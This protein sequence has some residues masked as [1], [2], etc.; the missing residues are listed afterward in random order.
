MRTYFF[1]ISMVMVAACALNGC[2]AEMQS[3]HRGPMGTETNRTEVGLG[4]NEVDQTNGKSGGAM[5]LCM[6][7]QRHDPDGALQCVAAHR[8]RPPAKSC[9]LVW[10][11]YGEQLYCPPGAGY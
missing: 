6:Y 1:Q 10:G 11:Y 3:V 4:T 5:S 8:V 7:E 9:Y 2:G